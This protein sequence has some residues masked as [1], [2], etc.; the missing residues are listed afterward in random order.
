MFSQAKETHLPLLQVL[1][2][3]N[4]LKGKRL[5]PLYVSEKQFFIGIPILYKKV[6]FVAVVKVPFKS[7]QFDQHIKQKTMD[8]II[9]K[10]TLFKSETALN[11]SQPMA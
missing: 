5:F 8:D 3:F 9:Q 11:C 10:H 4:I 2:N 7:K 6:L 1:R